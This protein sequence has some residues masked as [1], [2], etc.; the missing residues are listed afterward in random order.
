MRMIHPQQNGLRIRVKSEPDATIS[1][2]LFDFAQ[3]CVNV[4]VVVAAYPLSCHRRQPC[5][6]ARDAIK[7]QRRFHHP[8][9]AKIY[10]PAREITFAVS[11]DY[12]EDFI[13]MRVILPGINDMSIEATVKV[14][15]KRHSNYSG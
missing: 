15:T 12:F 5:V 10:G 7:I 8:A 9:V 6:I 14:P 11:V 2:E 1:R 4:I 13:I 3:K